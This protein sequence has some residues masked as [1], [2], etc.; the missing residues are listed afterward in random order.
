MK[1]KAFEIKPGDMGCI[2]N[3]LVVAMSYS[4]NLLN[5]ETPLYYLHKV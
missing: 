2:N 1:K 3:P 4:T 5:G